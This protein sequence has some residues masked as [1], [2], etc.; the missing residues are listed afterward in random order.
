MIKSLEVISLYFQLKTWELRKKDK[1]T[2]EGYEEESEIMKE[3]VD[4]A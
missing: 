2:D 3:I 4:N 1:Q